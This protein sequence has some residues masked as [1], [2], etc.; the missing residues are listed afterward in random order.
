MFP[1]GAN[2]FA[3][4][5]FR[6]KMGIAGA[7]R[8]EQQTKVKISSRQGLGFHLVFIVSQLLQQDLS[9]ILASCQ[10]LHGQ[11]FLCRLFQNCMSQNCCMVPAW[12]VM[13]SRTPG[14]EVSGW[15]MCTTHGIGKGSMGLR[16]GATLPGEHLLSPG[17]LQEC[18][19]NAQNAQH[20]SSLALGQGW[21]RAVFLGRPVQT[22]VVSGQCLLENDHG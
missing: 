7:D 15:V 3:Q 16:V 20:V 22:S 8:T 21:N 5:G 18:S 1:F 12:V 14:S 10:L 2:L 4:Q 11:A 9:V 19:R 6:D 17:R 13:E